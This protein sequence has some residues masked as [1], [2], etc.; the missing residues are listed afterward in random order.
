MRVRKTPSLFDET[1]QVYIVDVVAVFDTGGN[2][3]L[4]TRYKVGD[5]VAVTQRYAD[6]PAPRIMADTPSWRNKMF[7]KAGLMPHRIHITGLHA[8]G[9]ESS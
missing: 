2:V 1:D 6:I 4:G 7:V 9:F 3:R 5:M 8:G